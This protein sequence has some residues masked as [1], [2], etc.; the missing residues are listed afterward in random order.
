MEYIFE[1]IQEHPAYY[2][3]LTLL[4]LFLILLL[5]LIR[6]AKKNKKQHEI[7]NLKREVYE[8]RQQV[9][10]LYKETGISLPNSHKPIYAA[11]DEMDR[12]NH[13]R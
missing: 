13:Y 10:H 6:D 2:G 1:Y 9:K 8:L 3:S 12:I 7:E 5:C 11:G 4:L